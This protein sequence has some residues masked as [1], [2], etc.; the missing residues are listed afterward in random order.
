MNSENK[1]NNVALN[2]ESFGIYIEAAS[3]GHLSGVSGSTSGCVEAF[4]RL[5][6]MKNG[7]YL[8]RK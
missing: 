6:E 1:N 4:E 8:K 5:K 7:K 2:E 3:R